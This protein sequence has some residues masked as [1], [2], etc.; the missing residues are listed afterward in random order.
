MPQTRPSPRKAA[1]RPRK[2]PEEWRQTPL[3]EVHSVLSHA[4]AF[5]LEELGVSAALWLSQ[6]WWQP[7]HVQRGLVTLET[8][9]GVA[10]RRAGYNDRMIRRALRATGPVHADISGFRD[11]FVPVRASDGFRGVLVIGSILAEAQTASDVARHWRALTGSEARMTD[12][13]FVEFLNLVVDGLTLDRAKFKAFERLAACFARVLAGE[14]EARELAAEVAEIRVA[15]VPIRYPERMWGLVQRLLD[16]RSFRRPAQIDH[17]DMAIF[18]LRHMPRDVVVGYLAGKPGD[19]LAEAL[20]RARFQRACA[21]FSRRRGRT[22]CGRLGRQGVVFLVDSA[23]AGERAKA[24]LL[25]LVSRASTLAREHGLTLHTGIGMSQAAASLHQVYRG[26]LAAAERA[27]AERKQAVLGASL[28]E[29]SL[30]RVRELRAELGRSAG[31]AADVVS[32]RF[33]RYIDAVVT[34]AGGRLEMLRAELDVGLE[35]LIEP[36]VAADVL[37]SRSAAEW[38]TTVAEKAERA[39]TAIELTGAY[40]QVVGEIEVALV[41]PTKAR[42]DRGLNRALTYLRDHLEEPL[43]LPKVA[44][45]AGFAPE[46]FSRTFKR[47]LGLSFARYRLKLRIEKAQQMLAETKLSVEQIQRLAGF[48]S[49]AY[50]HTA[51]KRQVRTTPAEY[52]EGDL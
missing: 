21:E 14:G 33:N 43:A 11:L 2:K 41:D 17:S 27:V 48:R 15:L 52:R 26:A 8:E 46:Y 16:E 30:E 50:F 31:E 28:G 19:P 18:G 5:T 13:G 24:A 9:L 10:P 12:S 6:S 1:I 44:R 51:F 7:I 36:L 4:I 49:R 23:H 34:R 20:E 45:V 40:R 35:R 25:D 32:L 3:P 42:R 37:D 22:V 38:L 29:S 39:Q 47:E